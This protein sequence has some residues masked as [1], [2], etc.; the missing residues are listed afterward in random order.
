MKKTMKATILEALRRCPST[1]EELK[2]AVEEAGFTSHGRFELGCGKAYLASCASWNFVASMMGL[3]RAKKIR[4]VPT[5]RMTCLVRDPYI[6]VTK[7]PWIPC[8]VELVG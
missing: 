6:V 3:I 8:L 7:T 4:I 1:I 5:S 2:E